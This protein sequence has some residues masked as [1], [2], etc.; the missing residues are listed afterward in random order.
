MPLIKKKTKKTPLPYLKGENLLNSMNL[1]ICEG[2]SLWSFS[3]SAMSNLL[4]EHSMNENLTYTLI[5]SV[6]R[7][8]SQS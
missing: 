5:K 1:E 6:G 7:T 4:K 8:A 3:K 2:S